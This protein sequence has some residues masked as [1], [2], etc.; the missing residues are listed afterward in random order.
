MFLYT[1]IYCTSVFMAKWAVDEK[2]QNI[3]ARAIDSI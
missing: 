3:D 2:V 1:T